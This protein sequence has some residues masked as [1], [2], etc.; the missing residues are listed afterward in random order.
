[1]R[2]EVRIKVGPRMG[3]WLSTIVDAQFRNTTEHPPLISIRGTK[4][5]PSVR[6]RFA[7]CLIERGASCTKICV[8]LRHTRHGRK[9]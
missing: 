9:R 7:C 3:L 8:L 5:V 1:M 4:C 2:G 6:Y